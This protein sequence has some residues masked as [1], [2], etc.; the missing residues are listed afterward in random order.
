[1]DNPWGIAY[2]PGRGRQKRHP[3]DVYIIR[4]LYGVT[5][6][7]S[8]RSVGLI[9]MD[10]G[11]VHAT[12]VHTD[13]TK[14]IVESLPGKELLLSIQS[15]GMWAS[16]A[17][18]SG[19]CR[20]KKG[21]RNVWPVSWRLNWQHEPKA[22]PKASLVLAA[23]HGGPMESQAAQMAPAVEALAALARAHQNAPPVSLPVSNLVDF[24]TTEEDNVDYLSWEQVSLISYSKHLA[25]G[26]TP[27]VAG[28]PDKEKIRRA[29]SLNCAPHLP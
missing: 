11:I 29:R 19:A 3:D 25:A 24:A 27:L 14:G 4:A 17:P 16:D 26:R 12:V 22:S 7:G 8:P 21:E 9:D 28:L 13:G 18:G 5:E 10:G 20:I 15:G 23:D 2:G 1:V 6:D